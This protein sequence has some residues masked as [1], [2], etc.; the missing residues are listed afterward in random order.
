[1]IFVVA[2]GWEIVSIGLRNLGD[3]A[4]SERYILCMMT[5]DQISQLQFI[6]VGIY[7]IVFSCCFYCRDSTWK[8]RLV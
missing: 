3:G 4:R 2:T 1:M 6:V 5:I 8:P 7:L